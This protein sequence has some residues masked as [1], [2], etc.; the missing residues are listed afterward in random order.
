MLPEVRDDV[1]EIG[2]GGPVN[3]YASRRVLLPVNAL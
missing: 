3:V 2:L 1:I